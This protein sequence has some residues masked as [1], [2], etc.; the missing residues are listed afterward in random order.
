MSCSCNCCQNHN[1]HHHHHHIVNQQMMKKRLIRLCIASGLFLL[2]F[3]VDKIVELADVDLGIP[4][5]ILPFVLYFAIYLIQGSKI[6]KEAGIGIVNGY[7]LDE[8]FLM[9]VASLGAFALGIYSGCIGLEP[10]GFEEGCAVVIFYSIGEFFQDWALSKSE[11]EIIKMMD[12]HQIDLK[13]SEDSSDAETFISRFAKVYTPI[14]VGLA[15]AIAIIPPGVG[16][17]VHIN[18]MDLS[19]TTWIYRALS[20]IVVSCPCALVISIPLSFSMGIG[21]AG[22]SGIFVMGADCLEQVAKNPDLTIKSAGND[23]DLVI[24]SAVA[25]DKAADSTELIL[26]NRSSNGIAY[27]KK[28]ARKTMLIIRENIFFTIGIKVA[29]LALSACGIT[30]MWI[31]IFADEG[32]ALLAVLNAFRVASVKNK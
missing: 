20:F 9:S 29:V 27:V 30:N 21:C 26:M 2:L 17:F 15:I 3:I 10:D 8:N 5:W 4:N 18:D 7:F 11:R 16:L 32:I 23:T 13:K 24:V 28:I 14:V 1:E 22:K 6:L 12:K 31:A 25:S 19:W